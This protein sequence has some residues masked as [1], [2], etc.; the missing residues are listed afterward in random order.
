MHLTL[1]KSGFW[2]KKCSGGRIRPFFAARRAAVS[3]SARP[4]PGP[5]SLPPGAKLLYERK[6]MDYPLSIP[7][8]DLPPLSE[9]VHLVNLTNGLEAID[10]LERLGLSY[11]FTRIKS[12]AFEQCDFD[13]LLQQLDNHLLMYLALGKPVLVW[14][15]GSR[16]ETGV[17]R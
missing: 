1:I 4:I 10:A 6:V 15:L 5:A 3:G 17:P 14:D 8:E 9:M 12:T 13:R 2:G 11:S 7:A 16:R